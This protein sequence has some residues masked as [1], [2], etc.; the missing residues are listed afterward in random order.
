MHDVR[1]RMAPRSCVVE[2]RRWGESTHWGDVGT[3]ESDEEREGQACTWEEG[4][5][6][7]KVLGVKIA[8]LCERVMQQTLSGWEDGARIDMGESQV[9]DVPEEAKVVVQRHGDEIKSRGQE[10]DDGHEEAT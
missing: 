2:D 3:E 8:H 10:V 5:D 1:M 6:G 7:R 4:Y 9:T